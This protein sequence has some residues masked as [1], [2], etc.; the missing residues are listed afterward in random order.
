MSK[1]VDTTAWV[2]RVSG[3]GDHTLH[4]YIFTDAQHKTDWM[5][6]KFVDGNYSVALEPVRACRC[7]G[8]LYPLNL[9]RRCECLM[10]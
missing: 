8:Q 1:R 5:S 3:D 10:K 4:G 7:C 2:L 9:M 6:Q